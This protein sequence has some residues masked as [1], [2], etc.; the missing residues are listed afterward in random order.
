MLL[1]LQN[2][3]DLGYQFTKCLAHKSIQLGNNPVVR[4]SKTGPQVDERAASGY[5]IGESVR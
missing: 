4:V 2:P 3:V 5:H 1:L